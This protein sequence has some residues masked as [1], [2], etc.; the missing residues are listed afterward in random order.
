MRSTVRQALSVS[1]TG[2]RMYAGVEARQY[3][4]EAKI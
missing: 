2:S 4:D 1:D 3:N